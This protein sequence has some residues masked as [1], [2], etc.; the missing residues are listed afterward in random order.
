M[1]IDDIYRKVIEFG[2]DIKYMREDIAEMKKEMKE[3]TKACHKRIDR[4]KG[5]QDLNAGKMAVVLITIGAVILAGVHALLWFL[6][7]MIK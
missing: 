5:V 3:E 2:R 7:K 1:E 6:D 4:I